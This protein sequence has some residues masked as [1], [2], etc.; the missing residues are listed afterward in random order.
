MSRKEKEDLKRISAASIDRL[1]KDYKVKAGK[2]IRPP[3]PTSAVKKLVEIRTK[4]WE[5][6]EVGWTKVDTV[7]H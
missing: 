1:L 5:T 3:K 6:R 2:K 4:S 7:A